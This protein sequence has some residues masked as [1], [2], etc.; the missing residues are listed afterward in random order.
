MFY[1]T[2]PGQEIDKRFARRLVGITIMQAIREP[3]LLG[4]AFAGDPA[5]WEPWKAA[6]RALFGLRP[7]PNQLELFHQ[8]TGRRVA[9]AAPSQTSYWVIG[10]GGSKSFVLSLVAVYMACFRDWSARLAPGGK[11]IVML[12]A[13]TREQA[14]ILLGYIAG[15]LES[16]PILR[17][18]VSNVTANSAE[19]VNG[20][21]I[22]V[23]IP[24]YRTMRGRAVACAILDEAAFLRSDDSASPDYEVVAALMPSPRPIRRRQ[25]VADRLDPLRSTRRPI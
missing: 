13:P 23:G 24:N 9:P 3:A 17:K 5:T 19:L 11:P 10:R 2:E 25:H 8:C 1:T 21:T 6:L 18:L 22:E 12:L 4:S 15:I 7:L 14:K 16:S 20:V